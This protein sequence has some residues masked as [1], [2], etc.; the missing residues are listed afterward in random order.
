MAKKKKIDVEKEE[1]QEEISPKEENQKELKKNSKKEENKELVKVKEPEKLTLIEQ[2][3]RRQKKNMFIIINVV[4]ITILL[5]IFST[6]FAFM[7]T[8]KAVIVNG[9]TIKGIEVS[10]LT[11]QEARNKLKEAINIELNLPINL[12]C[13]EYETSLRTAQIEF[14]YDI[15][16]AVEDEY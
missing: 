16:K 7:N 8:T 12:E 14:E 1:K 3:E 5:G 15:A 6:I 9:V 2:Q 10:N 11:M 4:I 13:P